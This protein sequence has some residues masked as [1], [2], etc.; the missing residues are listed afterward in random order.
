MEPVPSSV[1]C[2][3]EIVFALLKTL[4]VRVPGFIT[5]NLPPSVRTLVTVYVIR[6]ALKL[7][8]FTICY[9]R[10]PFGFASIIS[11]IS[12]THCISSVELAPKVSAIQ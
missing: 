2:L 11:F 9:E 5:P 1:G 7:V 4:Q 12:A 3:H 6:F 8:E 10:L